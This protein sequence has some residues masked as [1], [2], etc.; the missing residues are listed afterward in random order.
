MDDIR[1]SVE[2]LAYRLWEDRGRPIGS[3]EVDWCRAE[4]ELEQAS[5]AWD[6]SEATNE[7][8][9]YCHSF[10]EGYVTAEGELYTTSPAYEST[11][12]SETRS[13]AKTSGV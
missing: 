5:R 1:E 4:K 12:V 3:P 6:L 13:R 8:E 11:G 10:T 9:S 7:S 2:K